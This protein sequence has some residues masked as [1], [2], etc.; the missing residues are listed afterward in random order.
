M[1]RIVTAFTISLGTFGNGAPIR[2]V[3]QVHSPAGVSSG[4]DLGLPTASGF[5]LRRIAM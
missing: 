5:Y 2:T 4:A 3:A 1:L